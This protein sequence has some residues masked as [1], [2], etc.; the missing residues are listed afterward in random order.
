MRVVIDQ[1]KTTLWTRQDIASLRDLIQGE[2][3]RA[4]ESAIKSW[5]GDIT[6]Y[7]LELYQW[8]VKAAGQRLA[9]PEGAIYPIWCSV[10]SQYM[11]R[12]IPGTVVYELSVNLDEAVF[13]D[14]GRWDMVLNHRFV[15]ETPEEEAAYQKDLK[16]KGF[17][18]GTTFIGEAMARRYPAERERVIKSWE[19]IF[20][21]DG[22]DMFRLQANLWE[23]RPDQVVRVSTGDGVYEKTDFLDL[24]QHDVA[25]F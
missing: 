15:P 1:K 14:G 22:L 25:I 18:E 24:A 9:R 2:N 20:Q 16:E 17:P 11:L 23:I 5:Y 7:Y 3:Y 10:S 21:A 13:F 6:P 19:R 8:F 4:K 12:P